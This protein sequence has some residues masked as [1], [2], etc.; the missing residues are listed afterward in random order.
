MFNSLSKYIGIFGNLHRSHNAKKGYA[1]HKPVLL[2]AVLDE[3]DRGH[4]KDNL[5]E[6][7]PEL[8]AS[9]RAYWRALVPANTWVERIV[10]PFR[11]LIQDGFWELV[12]NGVSQST[13]ALGDPTS[14]NQL[15]AMIDG[16]HLAPDLWQLLQDRTAIN[17]LRTFLL[18]EYFSVGAAD[19]QPQLPANPI[20]YEVEKLKAEAQ[21]KFRMRKVSESTD[22]TGYYVRHALFPK[23]VRTLYHDACA[24]C[25]LGVHADDGSGIVDAAHIM[26]FGIFHNDD[27]RNGI[28]FCKNHHWGFDEGWFA[29][30]DEY[31]IIVSS[32][33]RNALTYITA[34][35]PLVLP[36]QTEYAPALDALAWHRANVYK[37]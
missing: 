6:I 16:A 24:V 11:Y 13:Q 9:F 3:F 32:R 19:I 29:V 27:P 35:V 15:A 2:L 21:S 12:R 31:K 23:V 7:T 30:S 4:V 14:L 36:S 34:D 20:D 17:A 28:A 1:P 22:E 33:L 37:P 5:V 18:K 25:H 26:P 10:Y 8:V